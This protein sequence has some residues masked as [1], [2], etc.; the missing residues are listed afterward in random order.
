MNIRE[1]EVKSKSWRILFDNNRNGDIFLSANRDTGE[2]TY[3]VSATVIINRNI[4]MDMW[5]EG[6]PSYTTALDAIRIFCEDYKHFIRVEL[7]DSDVEEK[8]CRFQ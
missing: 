2:V 5:E 4:E 3:N 8:Y 6:F 1:F 7:S